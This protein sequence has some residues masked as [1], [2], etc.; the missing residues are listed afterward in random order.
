VVI[1]AFSIASTVS[2]NPGP[3]PGAGGNWANTRSGKI[4][5]APHVIKTIT[6]NRWK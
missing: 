1:R 6:A 5:V 4:A 3:V 2:G